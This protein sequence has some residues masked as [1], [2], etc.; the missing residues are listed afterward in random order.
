MIGPRARRSWVLLACLLFCGCMPSVASRLVTIKL[1][2]PP[3][4]E[5]QQIRSI[6][7]LPFESAQ[8]LGLHMAEEVAA[9]LDRKP[10]RARLLQVPE[11]FSWK[12]DSL[13][14]LAKETGVD[15]LLLGEVTEYAVGVSSEEMPM[16]KLPDPWGED[17]ANLNWVGMR[18]N[19][20]IAEA[21]YYR[22]TSRRA[23]EVVTVSVTRAHFA[24]TLEIRLLEPETGALLWEQRLSRSLQRISLPDTPLEMEAEI[25]AL[26]QS[27][28]NEV[29]GR[30]APQEAEVQRMLRAPGIAM[31]ARVARLMRKGIEAA[32]DEDWGSAEEF[33]QKAVELAPE[34]ASTNGNLG[35]VYEKAGRY[36]EAL[37]AYK[38]AYRCQPRDPTYRHYSNDLQTAFIPDLSR[39]ELPTLVLGIR[40]DGIL[41]LDAGGD[42]RGH[43]DDTFSV[44]RVLLKRD[45]DSHRIIEVRDVEIARGKIIEVRP[46]ISLGQVFMVNPELEIRGGDMVRLWPGQP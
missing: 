34:E 33:F 20:A 21:F 8:T 15:A 19:P 30:L 13:N 42:R 37:A 35:V 3:E 7:V 46:L 22:L 39:E 17:A 32:R 2:K 43:P 18:E 36:L 24:I 23:P 9:R 6:G 41:Y 4:V 25:Y 40:G 38:R 27:T 28:I 11:D 16:L 31:E 29:I 45:P 14:L 44:Y 1:V 12:P 5:L 26:Q 10:C